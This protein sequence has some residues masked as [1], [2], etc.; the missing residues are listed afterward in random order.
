MSILKSVRHSVEFITNNFSIVANYE[1]MED[2]R[3]ADYMN[4]Y[5]S[6]INGILILVDS[7]MKTVSKDSKTYMEAKDMAYSL[8][9]LINVLSEQIPQKYSKH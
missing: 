2:E 9:V 3:K 7:V 5:V 8:S 1:Q 6:N 4:E